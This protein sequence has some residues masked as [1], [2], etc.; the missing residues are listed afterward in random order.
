MPLTLRVN[1]F[2]LLERLFILDARHE[3][4]P[5]T[6]IPSSKLV[7]LIPFEAHEQKPNIRLSCFRCQRPDEMK[8]SL[9]INYEGNQDA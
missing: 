9:S 1:L 4:F 8:G 6:W 5:Y 3:L 7:I 2:Q